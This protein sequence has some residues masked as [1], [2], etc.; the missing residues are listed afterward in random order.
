MDV[1]GPSKTVFIVT[2]YFF[3]LFTHN[4]LGFCFILTCTTWN[5]VV[6]NV[7]T[8]TLVE[9]GFVIFSID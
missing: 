6:E 1:V 5:V 2:Y 8:F 4:V 7:F 3:T 9:L